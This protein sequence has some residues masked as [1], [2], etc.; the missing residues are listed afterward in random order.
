MTVIFDAE[1]LFTA[2]GGTDDRD[3]FPP[4]ETE[5]IKEMHGVVDQWP[6]FVR[7]P[8]RKGFNALAEAIE[9]HQLADQPRLNHLFCFAMGRIPASRM[10]NR[11]HAVAPSWPPSTGGDQR[12]GVSQ[13]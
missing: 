3:W 10:V 7:G 6:F 8:G 12:I 4:K 9:R 1:G 5:E 11:K 2:H 13:A